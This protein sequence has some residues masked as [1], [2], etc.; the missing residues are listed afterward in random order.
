MATTPTQTHPLLS[1]PV[2]A[3]TDF[4]SLADC[5]EQFAETLTESN[6]ATLRFALC[7]RLIA[8]LTWLQAMQN[9]PIPPHLIERLTVNALPTT[10]PSF[11]PDT[12]QLCGYCLTLT[13]LLTS[14][15]L[16]PASEQTLSDLLFGLIGYLAA[17]LKAPRWIRT[18]DG[19][20]LIEED[21][22]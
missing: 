6:D 8:C 9:D 10:S 4:I 22:Q 11:K 21:A 7:G 13:P 14:Q 3:A 2:S 12:E 15:T 1:I 19:V 5:Y 17:E 16:S 18:A 20:K